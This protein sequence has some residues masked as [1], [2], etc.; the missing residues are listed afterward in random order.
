M[1]VLG[2][3]VSETIV[4]GDNIELTV[5]AVQGGRVK[6]GISAP[7]HVSIRRSELAAQFGPPFATEGT[8]TRFVAEVAKTLA[9]P[10][11]VQT[12][13]SPGIQ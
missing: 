7:K 11:N 12:L 4:I 1:L 9:A 3:K 13:A 2:R 8:A 5:L 10:P 6:L